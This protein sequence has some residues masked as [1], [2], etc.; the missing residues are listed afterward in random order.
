MPRLIELQSSKL[1]IAILY[2][3][4]G[5]GPLFFLSPDVRSN[6]SLEQPDIAALGTDAV[7]LA[8]GALPDETG[9]QKTLPHVP[10][11]ASRENGHVWTIEDILTRAARS[12]KRVILLDEGGWQHS[13][14]IFSPKASF[15]VG[16]ARPQSARSGNLSAPYR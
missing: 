2:R 16:A 6:T 15:P 12:G 9:F 11:L 8:T 1:S 3:S 13:V 4:P 14:C 10:A 5:F 7:I